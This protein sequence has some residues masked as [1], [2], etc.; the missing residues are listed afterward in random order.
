[1]TWCQRYFPARSLLLVDFHAAN[2][3]FRRRRHRGGAP[4]QCPH[5]SP[6]R[7][8]WTQCASR[9]AGTRQNQRSSSPGRIIGRRRCAPDRTGAANRAGFRTAANR[10][11]RGHFAA[12]RRHDRGTL[13]AILRNAICPDRLRSGIAARPPHASTRQF[14]SSL[15]TDNHITTRRFWLTESA[16]SAYD[17]I[18]QPPSNLPDLVAHGVLSPL[19]GCRSG[20]LHR[21]TVPQDWTRSA[22]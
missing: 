17:A 3:R 19:A 20:A 7:G 6:S 2:H 8:I 15:L 13:C 12:G 11:S 1:M 22:I 14:A 16:A 21:N 18:V 5:A 9:P 4:L 10:C